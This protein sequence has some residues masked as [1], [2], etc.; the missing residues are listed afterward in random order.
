MRTEAL[1][2]TGLFDERFFLTQKIPIC[3]AGFTSNSKPCFIRLLKF[4]MS[5]RADLI[6]NATLTIHNLI[7][8]MKVLY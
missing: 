1:K 5:M 4:I 2:K 3:P 6:K 7:S 8:A